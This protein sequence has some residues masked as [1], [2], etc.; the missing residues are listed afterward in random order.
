MGRVGVSVAFTRLDRWLIGAS[1]AVAAGIVLLIFLSQALVAPPR[2]RVSDSG[3]PTIGVTLRELP[4]GLVLAAVTGPA[5][6]AGLR[7]GDRIARID[8]RTSPTLAAF[9]EA[10]AGR[11]EG[12]PV[13]IEAVRK[14]ASGEETRVLANVGVVIRAITPADLGLAYEDVSFRNSDGLTLRGWYLPPPTGGPARVPAVAYGHGNGTDRRHWLPEALAVHRAGFAQ[15]LFDFTGRGESD[16]DVITL[17]LHEAGDLRAACDLLAGRAEVDPLRLA[18][19]GR[20][21]G[22]VA[23]IYEAADDARVKALVL[24]SPYADL[25][26]LVGR[27]LGNFHIP[28]FVVLRPLLAVAGW[29]AN[30]VPASV[31]PVDAIRNV[32]VPILLF[33]GDHDQLVPFEDAKALQAAAV[34]P[35]TFVPLMGLD[36]NSPRP[37]AYAERIAAFLTKTLK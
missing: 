2:P 14:A 25:A 31:R 5:A 3:R 23:A 32:H 26:A 8:D 11:H 29:R 13:A 20:S 21:M 15:I 16:G 27:T 7:A 28:T 6:E 12:D 30:Y 17:G 19:A 36:H 35:L 37:D 4:A 10:V 24:D 1:A 18:I 9:E 22:A 34:A 33:H